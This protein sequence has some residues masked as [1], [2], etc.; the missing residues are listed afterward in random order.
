MCSL[1]AARAR[2][3]EG[4]GF[5]WAFS[6]AGSAGVAQVSATSEQMCNWCWDSPGVPTGSTLAPTPPFFFSSSD[7]HCGCGSGGFGGQG[8]LQ[9]YAPRSLP[10]LITEDNTKSRKKGPKRRDKRYPR[11]RIRFNFTPFLLPAMFHFL[12]ARVIALPTRREV[13]MQCRGRMGRRGGVQE[14]SPFVSWFA[15]VLA[16][17]GR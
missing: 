3:R 4:R 8:G 2:P 6:L 9:L 13:G 17:N 11:R 15:W 7:G 10:S 1:L 5:W 12:R 14:M 16:Q